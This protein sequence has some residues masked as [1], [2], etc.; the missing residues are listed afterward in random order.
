MFGKEKTSGYNGAMMKIACL[1]TSLDHVSLRYR[2]GQ[3]IPRL[4]QEGVAVEVMEI[5]RGFVERLRFFGRLSRYDLV[6]LH[7]RLF[8]LPNFFFLR[9][10]ARRLI[11]DVDDA[12]FV[13][14]SR[15]GARSSRTSRT[16]FWRTVHTADR[17]IAGNDYLYSK[18]KTINPRTTVLPTVVDPSR[19]ERPKK[20]SG[21]NGLNAVWIG[22]EATLFYL[23]ALLPHLE[24]LVDRLPG[25]RL[26]VISDRFPEKTGVPIIR[27]PW[28]EKDEVSALC[29]ADVG[30]APLFD[31]AW[32]RAK[33]GLKLIQYGAAGLPSVYSPVGL[34]RSIASPGKTGIS[35]LFGEDWCKALTRLA[36]DE[37]L[38]RRMGLA[39]RERI[40]EHYSL[41]RYFP[42]LLQTLRKTAAS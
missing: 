32:T 29:S 40:F 20:Q 38:R 36:V 9:R 6:L 13:K 17:V 24:P 3:Y 41:S 16:R 30:L 31:D 11:F 42:E 12:L 14:D 4:A 34:N 22:A 5:P 33:C 15:H 26:T 23:E 39:A 10:S 35:A 2:T 18:I 8:N 7:R 25:F 21:A 37:E 27:I 28:S 1:A 19:Y